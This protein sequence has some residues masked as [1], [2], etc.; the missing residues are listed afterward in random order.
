[1]EKQATKFV[2]TRAPIDEF[3][4]FKQLA[5]AESRSVSAQILHLM[6]VWIKQQQE[7]N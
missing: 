6:R 1:M 3:A 4:V 2:T 7:K 5:K